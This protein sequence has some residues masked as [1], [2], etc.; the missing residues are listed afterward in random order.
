MKPL[1]AVFETREEAEAARED[2]LLSGLAEGAISILTKD[3]LNGQTRN[4]NR[5]ALPP[6]LAILIAVPVTLILALL[7]LIVPGVAYALA[8][9]ALLTIFIVPARD[10]IL[11]HREVLTARL[12]LLEVRSKRAGMTKARK[13]LQRYEILSEERS[14][15]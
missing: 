9:I 10:S 6:A 15:S 11:D 14:S 13:I 1:R 5:R 8:A 7:V 2:L 12:T 3:D 4:G